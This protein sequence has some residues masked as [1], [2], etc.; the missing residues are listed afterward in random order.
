MSSN[1]RYTIEVA[2]QPPSDARAEATLYPP[3]VVRVHIHDSNGKEITGED[4][5]SGLFVQA[6]LYQES[7]SPPSLA[8]P[9][10]YLLSGRLSMS[11]DLLSESGSS[12]QQGSYALFPDLKINRPGR[13]RLGVSLFKVEGLKPVGCSGASNGGGGGAMLEETKTDVICIQDGGSLRVSSPGNVFV[14]S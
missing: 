9:D 7:G 3:L 2:V 4:E 12:P 5:L 8:P 1:R 6:T 13:Y 14:G 10:M 11:L